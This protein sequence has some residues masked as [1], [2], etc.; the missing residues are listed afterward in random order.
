MAIQELHDLF[1]ERTAAPTGVP[2][3]H[4]HGVTN[5]ADAP[6]HTLPFLIPACRRA[7]R[8]EANVPDNLGSPLDGSGMCVCDQVGVRH[9]TFEPLQVS[10]KHRTGSEEKQVYCKTEFLSV[11]Q[12]CC[13]PV[14]VLPQ[15]KGF[16]PLVFPVLNI[17]C[18][19]LPK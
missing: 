16:C 1:D 9:Q 15:T 14:A 19:C 12:Q 17:A 13:F 3:W 7:H 4:L 10:K 2:G 5:Q 8:D 6:A 11:G 18:E